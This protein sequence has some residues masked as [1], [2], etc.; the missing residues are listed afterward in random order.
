MVWTPLRYSLSNCQVVLD[1]WLGRQRP[2]SPVGKVG[3]GWRSGGSSLTGNASACFRF[4]LEMCPAPGS[5]LCLQFTLCSFHFVWSLGSRIQARSECA[6][7]WFS[8]SMLS[9]III[10]LL[11]LLC[12]EQGCICR[13]ECLGGSLQV[14]RVLSGVLRAK[15]DE[16]H[17]SHLHLE[18]QRFWRSGFTKH[19]IYSSSHH[20]DSYWSHYVPGT[21]S[22][23]KLSLETVPKSQ[24]QMAATSLTA[25]T[26]DPGPACFLLPAPLCRGCELLLEL[27]FLLPWV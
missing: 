12:S 15:G 10:L 23:T 11:P 25:V 27:L 1:Y 20:K 19:M 22:T 7:I 13:T 8:V 4:V 9:W 16:G 2:L 24:E 17:S 3:G 14:L 6:Q 5:P 18:N 21:L 26:S